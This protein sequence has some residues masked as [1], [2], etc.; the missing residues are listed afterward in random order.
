MK[1]MSREHCAIRRKNPDSAASKAV[2]S[3]QT[4]QFI[5]TSQ[6]AGSAP[7]QLHYT[8]GYFPARPP[9][10]TGKPQA[11]KPSRLLYRLVLAALLCVFLF[12]S[13]QV[14]RYFVKSHQAKQEEQMVQALIAANDPS[15][16]TR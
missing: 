9:A 15:M 6:E 2:Q 13:Y 14:I 4:G 5:E 1:R 11:A 8:Q 12:A 3:R 10:E 7:T 16:H